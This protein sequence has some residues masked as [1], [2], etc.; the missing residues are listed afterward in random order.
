MKK[1]RRA[2]TITIIR[3]AIAYVIRKSIALCDSVL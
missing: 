2:M 3:M 1:K